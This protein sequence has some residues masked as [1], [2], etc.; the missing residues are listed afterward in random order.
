M[1]HKLFPPLFVIVTL[2]ALVF[3][4]LRANTAQA[5]LT[6]S[7]G[8][9]AS[10]VLGQP[11][12]TSGSPGTSQTA[13]NSPYDVAV[14]P[15]TGKIFVVERQNHRVLRFA[16]AGSLTNGATAEA[17]LGQ[18]NFTSN[19]TS[20]AANG[21]NQP[22]GI[23]VDSAGRLWVADAVNN[24]VL[25]F[26]NAA[27]KANGANADGVL[28]QP[29]FGSSG[30]AVTQ[31][32]MYM[33]QEVQIDSAGRLWVAEYG[34]SRVTRFDNAAAKAN[35]ANADGVLGQ[36][37]FTTSTAGL[38]ANKIAYPWGLYVDS[39]GRLWLPDQNNRVLRF[40]NAAAKA[41]GANADGVLGQPDFTSNTAATTQNGM[42]FPTG[43]SGDDSIGRIYV[44]ESWG[45]NRVLVF[46]N[47]ASLANG[48]NASYVIGQ[49]S[50][51]T[52]VAATTQT[53]LKSP[54][55]VTYDPRYGV[56]WVAEQDNHRV[57]MYG[58]SPKIYVVN[59]SSSTVS[60]A[61]QDGT[62]GISLGNL[63]GTLNGPHCIALDMA[64]NR[65]FVTNNAGNTVVRANL[66]GT[67]ATTILGGFNRP[68]GIAL[69]VANN[70]MYVANGSSNNIIR[71][72]LDGS[73]VVDLGNLNGTLNY[74]SGITLDLV[75]GKM[76]VVNGTGS[77][78]S[79]GNLDG[80]GGVSL[81]TLGG[82]LTQSYTIALDVANNKM[83]VTNGSN[84]T[85]K[86]V[87]ANLD[88]SSPTGLGNPTGLNFAVGIALDLTN[89]KMY[90]ANYSAN[91]IT[92]ANLDGSGG[93]DL[94]TLN[95]TLNQPYCLALSGSI[96]TP[97]V[98]NSFTATS[99]SSSLN[100][101]ITAFTAS[102]NAGVTGYLITESATPPAVGAAGWTGTAPGTYTVGGPGTYTLYPWAKDAAGNVSAVY[103]SPVAVTVCSSAISVTSNANSGA[104]TLRQAITDV[105]AGGTITF[106]NTLSGQTIRLAS[107][108]IL[109]K[110]MT[111]DGSS[112]ASSVILNGDTNSSNT[113]DAG[114]VQIFY[115]YNAITPPVVTLRTLTLTRGL[116]D[117]SLYTIP[118]GGAIHNRGGTLN[119]YNCTITN[120]TA[121]NAG[122]IANAGTATI[123]NSTFSGNSATIDLGS[124]QGFGGAIYSG[125]GNNLTI[126]NSTFSGNSVDAAR[127]GAAIYNTGILNYANTI[128]ANSTGP[129]SCYNFNLGTTS[130]N[131][132]NLVE[133]VTNCGTPAFTSNSN[134]AAL[135]SYGGPT[136]TFAL[137][138][139]SA[140]FDAG[141]DATCSAAPVNNLDQRG[142]VRPVYAHCDIGAYE[143]T[144]PLSP[145]ET[146]HAVNF[147]SNG[148]YVTI[149]GLPATTTGS[150]GTLEAWVNAT[151]T[152]VYS[153]IRRTGAYNLMIIGG[154]LYVEFWP[155]GGSNRYTYNGPA[156]PANTWAHIAMTWNGAAVTLY[157]N[158]VA[159]NPGAGG[160]FTTSGPESFNV[161]Y[162][163][164][165]GQQFY[166]TVD[167]VRVW[168]VT[169]TPAQILANMNASLI[170]NEAGLVGLY[171][172]NEA[173]GT[174][175]ADSAGGDQPGTF[176][177][178]PTWPT[179]TVPTSTC[180]SVAPGA[181]GG[182]GPGGVSVTDGSGSL[183]AWYRA[184]RGVYTDSGCTTA[185][186]NGGQVACWK[187]QSGN[188]RNATQTVAGTYPIYATNQINGLPVLQFDGGNDMLNLP[189]ATVPTGDSPYSVFTT[190]NADTMG[191][192]G[193][194]GSGNYGSNNQ[195]NA[196]R[197]DP[198]SFIWNYWWNVDFRTANNSVNT[199]V[200]YALSFVY[201]PGSRRIFINGAPSASDA[202]SG[203]AGGAANNTIGRTWPAASEFWDGTINEMIIYSAGLNSVDQILV[204]NYLNAKYNVALNTG[205]GALD[206]YDG[207]A[208]DA[209]HNF[210]LDMAGI[211]RF[212][213]NNHTQAF[214]AGIIV[215]NRTFLQDNGDWLT[216]GHLTPT[217]GYTNADVPTSG[218]WATAPAPRRWARYWYFN[219]T[220]AA[221]TTGGTVDIIFD[222]SEGNMNGNSE[223]PAGP[224]S[225]YRLLKRANPT[226]QFSDIATA[227]AI[228]GDQVQFLGVDVALLGSNFTLGTLDDNAS[229][230]AIQLD[231]L[232]VSRV[233]GPALWSWLL[234]GG[235]GLLLG[236]AG[237]FVLRK[238]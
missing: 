72:N 121:V 202:A 178:D 203:R 5:A 42:N 235:A 62:G 205:G 55:K 168:N 160:P 229:P 212:G 204:E 30:Q 96:N 108:L 236:L 28:G 31:N 139:N 34:N 215:V 120:H 140:A 138:F 156:V 63:G 69:D 222:F 166:G 91:K 86:I 80:T 197:F 97:P 67:G 137:S 92:R 71:A 150:T 81:G 110:N 52:K 76:Y 33:P 104:G 119:I 157:V 164:I 89:G 163:S 99:P 158:G 47:A 105:C 133:G 16:A 210:D 127:Q 193:F 27:I 208:N 75:N 186:T 192:R 148:Q 144:S 219:R 194:L 198:G 116:G 122:A 36:P 53:G 100:I 56:L 106:D 130:T 213:G 118:V 88:G 199:G 20:N 183:E 185:A 179:S 46:D 111:I 60:Q 78:I 227:T 66:D 225:N 152:G 32:G 109:D 93:E 14:D 94:G 146:C 40:D 7:D 23:D 180:T 167:E 171:K 3:S 181:A 4:A 113:A 172:F 182:N 85:N 175:V 159:S 10:L 218:A 151:G 190:L 103:G 125:N 162:S 131:T 153:V 25:R 61:D 176:V 230:T 135:G 12:F 234:F 101:P 188:G 238:R 1:K 112:L 48:A 211:G 98:V 145:G 129:S 217:S 59:Y 57:L 174:T 68:W 126:Y 233:H 41:N 18:P 154:N 6:I 132:N 24:R 201:N 9:A 83:Y 209:N 35:G 54:M 189:D 50:F 19:G 17:V 77:T 136:Q 70:R 155:D 15:T 128:I 141:D 206:V 187:D 65:M 84:A 226:G 43:V 21:M 200:N 73:N 134:L 102:D 147:A 221:G 165:Y 29:G 2:L 184:D 39:G 123:V 95:G 224:A 22:M 232:S 87:R 51:T 170:G 117:S 195:T 231:S 11:N 37:D 161:G 196:F 207:D 79:M 237:A 49:T 44:S 26:D 90:V 143:I 214:S 13:M 58:I 74:P 114:D 191:A 64:N 220:D 216:F 228:V 8:M 223:T 38:T 142:V 149:A 115:I 107:R 173:S 124:G 177:S 169:R 45:N 82:L